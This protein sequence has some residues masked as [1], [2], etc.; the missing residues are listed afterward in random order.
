MHAETIDRWTHEHV[1]LGDAH[2]RNER[3]VWL[4]VGITAA[5][6]VAEIAGGTIFG[7]LALVADG[8]HMSTHAAA[9]SIAGLAYLFARR[10]LGDPRFAFGTGKFG[11]LASFASAI[12]L[13]MIALLIGYEAIQR[14][15]HPVRIAFA[16]AIPIAALGLVVNLS[17]AWLLGGDHGHAH[18]HGHHHDHAHEEDDHDHDDH[19]DHDHHHHDEHD[20]GHAHGHAAHAHD[21]NLR[22]AYVHVLADAVTSVLAIGGLLAAR[23]A[24]WTFMDPLVGLVGMGVILSWAYGLVRD[25]GGVLLDAAPDQRLSRTVRE[26]LEIEGDRVADQHLWRVGPGHHAA[27]LTI[28]T[29][30]P[31]PPDVYRGR[32]AGV[33]GLSHVTVEV[34]PC[35]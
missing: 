23:F 18:G 1:F 16:E 32:L 31:Q 33:P 9:L 6:M 34:Q 10:H 14:L 15:L 27:V 21:L 3:R 30:T 25:A 28:V 4:V 5:M 8:W 7:S 13:A 19:D 24:G 20:H 12:I 2:Q 26:R 11:D 35:A 29:H 22:A 17:S